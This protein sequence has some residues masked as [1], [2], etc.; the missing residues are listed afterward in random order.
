MIGWAAL[1]NVSGFDLK[2]R[3]FCTGFTSRST[4]VGTDGTC[5]FVQNLLNI[6]T[7]K[8]D[9]DISLSFLSLSIHVLEVE[10]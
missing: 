9:R 4:K 2:R 10:L 3:S 5:S 1:E 6:I 7:L 8:S